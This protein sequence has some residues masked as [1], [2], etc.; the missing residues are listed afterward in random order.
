MEITFEQLHK[1]APGANM[2][3]VA[4]INQVLQKYQINTGRRIRY[5][6]THCY[7]ETE[8]FTDFDEDLFYKTPE[9]IAAVWPTRFNLDGSK[10]L[11]DAHLYVRDEQKLANFVYANRYG[12]G[13]VNS[14]DGFKFRGRGGLNTTFQNNYKQYSLDV[15]GDLRMLN[16]PDLLAKPDDAM[17]SAGWFWDRNK[18]NALA[19]AD[20]FTRSTAVV[21][22][23]TA[24]VSERLKILNISN[25]I[26][27]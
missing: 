22:G 2:A 27:L 13:D 1:F 7:E 15:Y 9:H 18:L 6:L 23:S 3:L 8:G 16:T 21:N 19:D 10:G 17:L 11:Q 5:F 20:Q 14:G 26:F 25:T 24:T 12:N 4:S